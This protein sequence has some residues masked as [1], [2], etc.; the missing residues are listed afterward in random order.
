MTV[1]LDCNILVMCLTSRSP[2]HI[3]YQSLIKG[4]FNLT[5]DRHFSML[6]NI[7]F[8]KVPTISID[9][10]TQLIGQLNSSS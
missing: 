7:P 6:R 5:E 8:P 4:K 9:D 1:V 10:F 2:F 3:I